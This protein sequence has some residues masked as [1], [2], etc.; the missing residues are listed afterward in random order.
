[1]NQIYK[2]R[3]EWQ[4]RYA[5]AHYKHYCEKHPVIIADG[6]YTIPVMPSVATANGLTQAIINYLDWSGNYGNR[7]NSMGRMIKAGKDV[8]T[9]A[10][11]IKARSIMIK[12]STKKGSEDID[13]IINGYPVKI[14]IKVGSDQQKEKQ[15]EHEAKI[16]KAGGYYFIVRDI[17]TFFEIFDKFVNAPKLALFP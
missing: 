17:E 7:I 3:T 15:K 6:F 14:E 5:E 1:M 8:H 13:C 11:T 4:R 9:I 12:G 10:G 16:N 2:G